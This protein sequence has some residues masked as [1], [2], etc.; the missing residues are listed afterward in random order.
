MASMCSTLRSAFKRPASGA[1]VLLCIALVAAAGAAEREDASCLGC[2]TTRGLSLPLPSGEILSLTVDVGMLRSSVHSTLRCSACHSAI[3]KYPHPKNAAND[4]REFQMKCN[5]QCQSCHPEQFKQQLDSTH[6]RILAAGN[7]NGAICI[8]C[9]GGHAVAKPGVP[10][11]RIST[12]CGKCHRA[13]YEQYLNSVHGKALL[14]TSNP[15]VPVCT[16]CHSAHHQEDPT[17]QAF[18]M[19]SP[20]LCA[21]CHGNAKIMR[22]YNITPDV[23]NTYVADFH[24]MTVTLFEKQ[25]PDQQ[26]NTAVCTDCHGIH[27]IQKVT[28]A[29]STVIK[30]N[31]LSTCRRCHPDAT[32]NFPNSWVGH[33]PPSRSRYPLVYYVNLFYRFL[34]PITIGAMLL[35]AFIDAGGRIIRRFRRKGSQVSGTEDSTP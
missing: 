21:K 7:Q 18:R 6:A 35:F 10:R 25:H 8:D 11:H 4:H 33:F 19:K 14:E 34:I 28:D 12:N 20:K 1:A 15:D 22:K 23:F 5:E 30:Q 29:N 26:T 3:Q 17:T 9:H 31:L 16:D 27:D 24:G 2:H 32:T 13:I